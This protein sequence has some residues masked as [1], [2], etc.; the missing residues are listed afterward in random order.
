MIEQ[1]IRPAT[2]QLAGPA[3]GGLAALVINGAEAV[4]AVVWVS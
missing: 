4:G 3:L 1:F 2:I